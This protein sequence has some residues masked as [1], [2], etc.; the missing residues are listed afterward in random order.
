RIGGSAATDDDVEGRRHLR[1][2]APSAPFFDVSLPPSSVGFAQNERNTW[3]RGIGPDMTVRVVRHRW[4][5]RALA[6]GRI[7]ARLHPNAHNVDVDV[8]E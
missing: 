6:P 3:L 8:V 5:P 7:H 4:S 2:P 1:S